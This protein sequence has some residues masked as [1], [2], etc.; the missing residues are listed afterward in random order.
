MLCASLF[1]CLFLR[2][3][4]HF[5]LLCCHALCRAV[6]VP[7]PVPV[8]LLVLCITVTFRLSVRV[9]LPVC[10][11]WYVCCSTWKIIRKKCVERFCEVAK[12]RSNW[13]HSPL[14]AWTTI[15]SRRKNWNQL[16][17]Y[18]QMLT[19]CLKCLYLAQIG[20]PGILWS[21]FKLARVVTKW[22][23][24][25]DR[26]FA[27]LISYIHHTNDC[28]QCCHVGN[29]AQQCRLGLFQNWNFAGDLEDSKS[30]SC[31]L[32]CVFGSHTFVPISWMCKKQTS[33]SHSSTEAEIISLDAGLRMD[34]I[35]ALD[36]WDVVIE[37]LH[38]FRGHT[39]SSERSLLKRKGRCSSR[40]RSEIQ[41]TNPNTK[42]QGHNDGEVGDLSSVDY[43][44][45][46]AKLSDFGV[47][48]YFF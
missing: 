45:T 26:R 28:R 20:R 36:L 11:G 47:L 9:S 39:S 27:R 8:H 32:L 19:D 37:V 10:C 43:V 30:T 41:I 33:F 23:V 2:L 42:T 38:F 22:T 3:L 12:K 34:G 17:N 6:P 1:V 48:P 5:V 24:A 15:T 31:R 18:Q 16:E 21:V 13:T 40:E 46:S 35:P 14:F 4:V 25:R 7:V 44:V 29:T